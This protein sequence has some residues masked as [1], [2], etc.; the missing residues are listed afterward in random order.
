[1][2]EPGLTKTCGFEGIINTIRKAFEKG[3]RLCLRFRL[4]YRY[5]SSVRREVSIC[6]PDGPATPCAAPFELAVLAYKC[7]YMRVGWEWWIC[8]SMGANQGEIQWMK[9]D[10]ILGYEEDNYTI[11]TIS[12]SYYRGHMELLTRGDLSRTSKEVLC[13]ASERA[14]ESSSPEFQVPSPGRN[15]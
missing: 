7:T 8:E 14:I 1:M 13:Y 3:C 10:W 12:V 11:K 15:P 6:P 2:L 4:L 5:V 9:S